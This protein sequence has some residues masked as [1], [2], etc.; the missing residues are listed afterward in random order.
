[1]AIK[2]VVTCDRCNREPAQSYFIQLPDGVLWN[3]D[4]CEVHA[5]K[6]EE[7]RTLGIGREHVER[8]GKRQTFA[9]TPIDLLLKEAQK[10]A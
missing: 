5:R 2:P 4:L 3:A 6:I 7:F 10:R 1:M 8:K 9:Q